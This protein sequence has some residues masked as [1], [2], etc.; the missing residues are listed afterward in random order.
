[1]SISLAAAWRPRGELARFK[2]LYPELRRAYS[3][4]VISLPPQVE[5]N[6]LEQLSE[7][8]Q[9]EIVV[10]EEWLSGRYAALERALTYST[11]YI[12]YADFDR[13]PARYPLAEAAHCALN[14][15]RARGNSRQRM[16]PGRIK[17]DTTEGDHQHVARICSRMADDTH[18]NH[19]GGEETIA[20]DIQ[21]GPQP[22]VDKTAGLRHT[23]AQHSHKYHAH[24]ME[25]GEVGH[26]HRHEFGEDRCR[27]HPEPEPDH[28]QAGGPVRQIEMLPQL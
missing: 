28:L 24:R 11:E 16:S 2:R 10:T 18:C 26:H 4:I 17:N 20:G 15:I 27:P 12:Q 13:L 25:V 14:H 9:V 8:S 21:Q 5:G 3:R 7:F 6:L 1:M 22:G 23:N 19:H